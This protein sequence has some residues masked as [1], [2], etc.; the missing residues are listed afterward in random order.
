[1][2][3]TALAILIA[4]PLLVATPVFAKGESDNHTTSVPSFVIQHV[5]SHLDRD[6]DSDRD[7]ATPSA[8]PTPKASCNPNYD[9]RNHGEYV[10]CVAHLHDKD[11][12]VSAAAKSDIGKR[13]DNDSDDKDATKSGEVKVTPIATDSAHFKFGPMQPV[14][15]EIQALIHELQ[16][17]IHSLQ[18]LVK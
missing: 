4:T 12:T 6:N 8:R 18:S 11:A 15:T 5:T 9:W 14:S 7:N 1:M 13:H 2:T 10:S 16:N 17:L 3:K